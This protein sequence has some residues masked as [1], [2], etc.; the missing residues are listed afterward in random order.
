MGIMV[1]SLLWVM[2]IYIILNRIGVEAAM[3]R[4]SPLNTPCRG[5]R[6]SPAFCPPGQNA[7]PLRR[8]IPQTPEV[9]FFFTGFVESGFVSNLY[10]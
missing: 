3:K 4:F 2:R 1:Y 5:P 7:E 6:G 10:P 8:S 9:A